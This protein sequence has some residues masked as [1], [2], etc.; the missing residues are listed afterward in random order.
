MLLNVLSKYRGNCARIVFLITCIAPSHYVH[1]HC[2]HLLPLCSSLAPLLII[3]THCSPLP[4]AHHMNRFLALCSFHTR[5]SPLHISC[6]SAHHM[7]CSP[8]FT[9]CILPLILLILYTAPLFSLG[10]TFTAPCPSAH[11]MHHSLTFCLWHALLSSPL[12]FFAFCSSHATCAAPLS[13][14]LITCT[15]PSRSAHHMYCFLLLITN[16]I[17]RS[18]PPCSSHVPIGSML[19]PFNAALSIYAH[20]MMHLSPLCLSYASLPS[21][22]DP[23]HRSP[24][25]LHLHRSSTF[26]NHLQRS[27]PPPPSILIPFPLPTPFSPP[28]FPLQAKGGFLTTCAFPTSSF[29]SLGSHH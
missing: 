7:H 20:P 2:A 16:Y 9:T 12:C 3:C 23:M 15:A 24:S 11:H 4:F 14:L 10:I 26:A 6:P 28:T 29:S 22:L 5:C 18:L 17:H 27:L 19:I 8:L 13:L 1:K 25:L 21:V